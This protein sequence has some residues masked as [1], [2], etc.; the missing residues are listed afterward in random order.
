MEFF[1]LVGGMNRKDPST[2]FVSIF[3]K[4]GT[5][6]QISRDRRQEILIS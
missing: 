5:L 1:E 6:A 3:H 2:I 4:K